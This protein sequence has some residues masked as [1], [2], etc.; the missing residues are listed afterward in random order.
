M[1]AGDFR[2]NGEVKSTR[3]TRKRTFDPVWKEQLVLS[4]LQPGVSVSRIALEN[5]INANQLRKWISNH[6]LAHQGMNHGTG[7]HEPDD[8]NC[9]AFLPVIEKRALK[10]IV[11]NPSLTVPGTK[12]EA[13]P[14]FLDK[15]PSV[16]GTQLSASLPNGVTLCV[17]VSDAS[18]LT[19]MIGALG[20][21]PSVG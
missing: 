5:R 12:P 21:V 9:S 14:E 11:G 7:G 17:D 15:K 1:D 19:A 18:I 3:S 6:R 10:G 20:N 2:E 13:H 4:C 8:L 16:P